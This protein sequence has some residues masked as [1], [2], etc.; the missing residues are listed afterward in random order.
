MLAIVVVWLGTI[1]RDASDP[2]V[3]AH[4][5]APVYAPAAGAGRVARVN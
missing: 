3:H 2:T 4:V 1:A 5:Y